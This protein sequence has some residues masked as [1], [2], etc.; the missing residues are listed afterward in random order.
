MCYM[1]IGDDAF[2]AGMHDYLL[3]NAYKNALTENL[4]Q[5]LGKSSKL[6]VDKMMSTWTLQKGHP[7]VHVKLQVKGDKR[8]LILTQE[9]F[10]YDNVLDEKEK[11]SLWQIP[12]SIT[13]AKDPVKPFYSGLMTGKSLEIS[14]DSVPS[15]CWIKLNPEMMGF[16]RVN[17]PQ[18]LL[19][20]L[21]Q[22]IINKNLKPIDRL[23]VVFD[24]FSMALAGHV[25]TIEFL[26]L[27]TCYKDEDDYVTWVAIDESVS[28]LNQ[29][30]AYTDC[31]PLFH[32]FVKKLYSN[33]FQKLGFDSTTKDS[34]TDTLLRVLVL[35]RLASFG[36]ERVVDEAKKR[37][38]SHLN[39][40]SIEPDI[41]GPIYHVIASYGSDQEFGKLFEVSLS[42]L[43]SPNLHLSSCIVAQQ[44]GSSRRKDATGRSG[45]RH[46]RSDQNSKG[47]G[48]LFLG[49]ENL[50]S[51]D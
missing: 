46:Q 21:K 7:V 17:Y 32:S 25:P 44:G 45:C 23:Q 26:K 30:L 29:L 20:L 31:Q 4:W 11:Q 48:L 14:I 12:I 10:S 37:F 51:V 22:G 13:S 27:L 18:D 42:R 47:Y 1:W 41:R 33:I 35:Q 24:H 16:Y 39:E 34:H 2:R 9:R 38:H 19:E 50:H 6:E 28:K 5:A 49:K 43:I 15:D 40:K 3:T 36:D 8:A